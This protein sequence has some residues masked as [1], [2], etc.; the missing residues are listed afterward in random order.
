MLPGLSGKESISETPRGIWLMTDAEIEALPDPVWMIDD[1]LVEN[2]LCTMHGQWGVYKSFLALALVLHL[3]TG[4]PWHGQRTVRADTLY[5]VGEGLGGLKLRLEAWKSHHGVEG[6]IASFRAVPVAVNLMREEKAEELITAALQ[7]QRRS[8]FHPRL[9]VVDTL[10]R[11]MVGGN[12]NSA[13]D[14]GVVIGNAARVQS[15]LGCTMMLVHHMGKDMERGMRG[16]TGLPGACDTILRVTRAGDHVTLKVEKQ[17]DGCEPSFRLRAVK[18]PLAGAED[19]L[20]PRSSLVMVPVEGEAEDDRS[21]GLNPGETE[22]LRVLDSLGSDWVEEVR[23]REECEARRCLSKSDDKNSRAKTYRRIR[24]ALVEK[25]VVEMAG[26]RVR[27]RPL[28]L[29]IGTLL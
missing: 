8:G 24:D 22:A 14:V 20:K 28:E 26:D 4:R 18:V 23:W 17:K 25:E 27:R 15:R 16:S 5:I 2:T 11:A 13:Q 12:E 6:S 21:P 10:H 3:A 1:V 9:V 19:S 29:D 7:E